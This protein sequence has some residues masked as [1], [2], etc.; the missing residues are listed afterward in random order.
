[1]SFQGIINFDLIY[2]QSN[3]LTTKSLNECHS[4]PDTDTRYFRANVDLFLVQKIGTSYTI[5]E[6]LSLDITDKAIANPLQ[7]SPTPTIIDNNSV[8]FVTG[9]IDVISGAEYYLAVGEVS[10]NGKV[11][12]NTGLGFLQFYRVTRILLILNLH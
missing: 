6:K 1:M 12:I 4:G 2:T 9:E 10:Y 7:L 8:S 11:Q 3:S 5:K